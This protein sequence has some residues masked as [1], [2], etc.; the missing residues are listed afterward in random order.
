MSNYQD[1]YLK[2][3]NKYLALKAQISNSSE[4]NSL[5]LKNSESS[6]INNMQVKILNML[7]GA[8][9]DLKLEYMDDVTETN[10]T[11]TNQN[12]NQNKNEN[13]EENKEEK[14]EAES[15]N[16]EEKFNKVGGARKVVKATKKKTDNYKKH[17]LD[18]SDIKD[19]S[20][21][22]TSETEFSSSDL[23]W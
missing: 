10:V 3:K 20:E 11:V 2:Y 14:T 23:D 6:S 13:K 9:N 1:K 8:N 21:I 15:S 5:F 7:G 16:V 19:D 17:F 12:Q 22:S 18:D 4:Q